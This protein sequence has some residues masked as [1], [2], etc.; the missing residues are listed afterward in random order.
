ME[1]TS[2]DDK[3]VGTEGDDVICGK[4]GDD[5]LRGGGGN[6]TLEGGRGNDVLSAGAGDDTL[7]G[8]PGADTIDYST[9]RVG[10]QAALRSG[11]VTAEGTDTLLATEHFIGSPRSDVVAGTSGSDDI[12][13]SGGNDRIRALGGDDTIRGGDGGDVIMG[14]QGT[15][16][17]LQ[18]PGSGRVDCER[19][20]IPVPFARTAGL[21]LMEPAQDP[22]LIAF[23]ES[24]FPSAATM[25]PLG[26]KADWMT[27]PSRGRPTTPTSAVD[28]PLKPGTRVV[29]PI[30]GTVMDVITYSLYC[31]AQDTLVVIRPAQHRDVTVIVMHLAEVGVRKGDE[32]VA[33]GTLLGEPHVFEGGHNQVEDYVPGSPPHVHIEVE[34][35]GSKVVP[36]CDYPRG[37]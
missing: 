5:V 7:D 33:G 30:N 26:D 9:S 37:G 2:K 34:L 16:T 8:G 28:I 6:D 20:W 18:G 11:T 3:L 25:K 15:D 24:L 13:G 27:Q 29:S 19:T 31:E 35:D 32:A 14:G 36:G 10:L 22:I 21:T 4:G 23:H 12:D 1:G 17:C